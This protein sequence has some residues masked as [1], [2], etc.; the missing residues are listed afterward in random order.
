VASGVAVVR[1]RL[2]ARWAHPGLGD[3][4][5]GGTTC[6]PTVVICRGLVSHASAFSMIRSTMPIRSVT[7]AIRAGS[8]V[9]GSRVRGHSCRPPRPGQWLMA[10]TPA[11]NHTAGT[12]R[13]YP[14]CC[15]DAPGPTSC[16][17]SCLRPPKWRPKPSCA[18][19]GAD[20]NA[21][22]RNVLSSCTVLP[23]L[24]I[25]RSGSRWI[26]GWIFSQPAVGCGPD[27]PCPCGEQDYGVDLC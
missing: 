12:P 13:Q 4:A 27:R 20:V 3:G 11:A 19:D 24:L 8:S 26:F 22:A 1:W 6:C 7:A 2:P 21:D 14:K 16:R 23:F 18:D 25:G 17:R 10:E 9:A 15:A 5:A